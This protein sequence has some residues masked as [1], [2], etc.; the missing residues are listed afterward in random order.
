MVELH[1]VYVVVFGITAALSLVVALFA[2]QQ[3]NDFNAAALTALM[4][5]VT[6]WCGAEAFLWWVPSLEQQQFWLAMTYPGVFVVVMALI[7]FAFEIAGMAEWQTPKRILLIAIAPATMAVVA[8]TNPGGLV[9]RSFV[10]QQMG[11]HTHYATQGGSLFLLYLAVTYALP[12]S[13]FYLIGRTYLRSSGTKRIQCRLVL[14]GAVLPFV[15]SIANQL[16][17]Q[18]LE[19]LEAMAFFFTGLIWLFALARGSL[20]DS[21]E[22]LAVQLEEVN[23]LANAM[24]DLVAHDPSKTSYNRDT[25]NESLSREVSRSRRTGMPFALLALGIDDFKQ[26]AES[27]SPAVGEAALELVGETL[28]GGSR[29]VDMVCRYIDDEFLIVMPATD[30]DDALKRA[31]EMRTHVDGLI[32]HVDGHD[33]PITASVGVSAFPLHG[34]TDAQAI[35]AASN[36]LAAARESGGGRTVAA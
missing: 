4:L 12:L 30:I 6:L 1:H 19:G 8:M 11:P 17:P 33:V 23:L 20:L 10:A 26:I 27:R 31:E 25:L 13:A 5:G 36:A 22:R 7:V 9:Y 2:W 28:L 16:R 3:R 14:A 15:V 34:E 24:C 18:Q 29:A 35:T 21:N 32:L